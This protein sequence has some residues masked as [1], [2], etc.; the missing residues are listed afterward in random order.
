MKNRYKFVYD[1]G[2]IYYESAKTKE[3]AI[4]HHCKLYDVSKEWVLNY[5]KIVNME[6]E[7]ILE[8]CPF[9]GAK[10]MD[11]ERESVFAH[12]VNTGCYLDGHYVYNLD[13]WNRR[14]NKVG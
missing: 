5:C 12:P 9:C 7:T 10:L 2:D 4:Y 14:N 8:P 3:L 6:V 11:T 1:T 13:A